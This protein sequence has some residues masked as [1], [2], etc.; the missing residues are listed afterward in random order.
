MYEAGACTQM[1]PQPLNTPFSSTTNSTGTI[2][3][4]S[5]MTNKL[6]TAASEKLLAIH[7][8]QTGH[9]QAQHWT[10]AQLALAFFGKANSTLSHLTQAILHIP[11]Q[12]QTAYC[13][14]LLK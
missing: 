14:L 7:V 1:Y 3:A 13:K 9:K 5:C 10:G 8:D 2:H 6:I 12:F 4:S 11:V